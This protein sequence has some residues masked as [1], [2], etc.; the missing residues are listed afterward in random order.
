MRGRCRTTSQQCDQIESAGPTLRHK[1]SGLPKKAIG[2][3]STSMNRACSSRVPPYSRVLM[4][5]G[6]VYNTNNDVCSVIRSSATFY[7]REC[8]MDIQKAHFVHQKPTCLM[9]TSPTRCYRDRVF[10]IRHSIHLPR[11]D[12]PL[13]VCPPDMLVAH[14]SNV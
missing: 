4:R 9:N 8:S 5:G 1:A 13:W 6:R 14:C 3:R 12:V 2:G 10:V 11:T 7:N